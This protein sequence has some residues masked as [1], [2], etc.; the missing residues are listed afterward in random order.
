MSTLKAVCPVP[1]LK[2]M[3]S[4]SQPLPG[5]LGAVRKKCYSN[6]VGQT[7]GGGGTGVILG[8]SKPVLV[9][10]PVYVFCCA[11]VKETRRG[12]IGVRMLWAAGISIYDCEV[13]VMLVL[14]WEWCFENELG[15]RCKELFKR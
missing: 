4:L 8:R 6:R 3:A 2:N 10:L 13:F 7:E 15:W 5:M 9:R 11:F 14:L 12:K 1:I